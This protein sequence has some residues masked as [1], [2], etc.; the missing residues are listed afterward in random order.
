MKKGEGIAPTRPWA[1]FFLLVGVGLAV[2]MWGDLA[3]GKYSPKAWIIFPPAI[4]MGMLGLIDPRYIN[5]WHSTF[6]RSKDLGRMK[7]I[8]GIAYAMS[9][10][11]ALYFAIGFGAGF[12]MP[13]FIV[14]RVNG[15]P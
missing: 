8:S 1:G 9:I 15:A 13:A 14:N 11:I 7:V 10:S 2:N 3:E 12:P 4:M 6:R 5:P